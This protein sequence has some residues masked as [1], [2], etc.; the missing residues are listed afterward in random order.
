L[1]YLQ[2]YGYSVSIISEDTPVVTN[3]PDYPGSLIDEHRTIRISWSESDKLSTEAKFD[4]A[5]R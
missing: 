2:R 3:D 1:T 4:I 5:E